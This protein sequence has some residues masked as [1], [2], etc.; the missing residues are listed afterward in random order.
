MVG[1]RIRRAAA[2]AACAVLVALGL[3]GAA[4][5]QTTPADVFPLNELIEVLVVDREML[6][7]DSVGTKTFRERLK[8]DEE[9][10]FQGERGAVGVIF[11]TRRALAVTSASSEWQELQWRL[12]ERIPEEPLLGDRLALLATGKRL[13]GFSAGDGAWT[14][15]EVGPNETVLDL[16]AGRNSA[17]AVTNRRALAISPHASRFFETRLRVHEDIQNV[18]AES[19]LA[20]ITTSQ[21]ILVFRSATGSWSERKRR[22]R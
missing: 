3:P 13:L 7:F 4:H 10:L 17:V 15:E 19:N 11:T 20:T 2:R 14:V 9:V 18:S 6:A 22:L 12:D 8:I 1:E 5:A 21:R 16:Q